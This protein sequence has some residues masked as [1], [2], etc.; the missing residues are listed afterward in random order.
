ME[1]ERTYTSYCGLYCRDCIP[2]NRE[3]F[4]TAAELERKLADL[5]FEEYAAHKA[6]GDAVFGGYQGFL[7]VLQGILG[8]ECKAPCRAGGGKSACAVR[9]CVLERQLPGCWDCAGY[10][11]CE[12]LGPLR[13]FHPNLEHHLDLI[14]RE[15]IDAWSAK[16]K[17]HYSWL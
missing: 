9:D 3:L 16:R 13:R 6:K 7:K 11:S 10:R 12:L 8:L 1:A 14:R 4:A 17:G 2:S 15:G 5:H